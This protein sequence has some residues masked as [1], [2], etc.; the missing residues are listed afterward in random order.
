VWQIE[1]G[2]DRTDHVALLKAEGL[3]EGCAK[4]SDLGKG[5]M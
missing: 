3:K 2:A 4:E 5:R 1:G